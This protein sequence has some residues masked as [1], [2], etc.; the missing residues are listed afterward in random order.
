MELPAMGPVSNLLSVPRSDYHSW[1]LIANQM[2]CQKPLD[3]HLS[4]AFSEN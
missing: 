3:D 4:A 1:Q 2:A